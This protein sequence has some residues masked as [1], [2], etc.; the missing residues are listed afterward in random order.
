MVDIF[1]VLIPQPAS[2]SHG[3]PTLKS[4]LP[5]NCATPDRTFHPHS[6]DPDPYF[7]LLCEMFDALACGAPKGHAGLALRVNVQPTAGSRAARAPV[8]AAALP[9]GQGDLSPRKAALHTQ[10]TSHTVG[11]IAS[12][13][14]EAAD[15]QSSFRLE[16]V[17]RLEKMY[18]MGRAQ[19]A[20]K[21]ALPTSEQALQDVEALLQDLQGLDLELDAALEVALEDFSELTVSCPTLLPGRRP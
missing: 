9:Y 19:A 20:S 1:T 15:L 3:G 2:P 7:I 5:T 14:V 18:K 10:A 4:P 17:E 13:A 12:D 21:G 11:P 8:T 16:E 6:P